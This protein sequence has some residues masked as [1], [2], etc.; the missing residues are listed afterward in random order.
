QDDLGEQDHQDQRNDEHADKWP[1]LADDG[2]E[3]DA[4]DAIDHEQHHAVGRRDQA[5]HAI[6]HRD[7]AEIDQVDPQGPAARDEQR[8]H[9]QDDRRGV[10]Q[11]AQ[12]QQDEIDDDEEGERVEVEAFEV[13]GHVGGDVL[14]RHDVVE[15]QRATDDDADRGGLTGARGQHVIEATP[16]QSAIDRPRQQKGI[17]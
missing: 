7:N 10:E 13:G 16:A 8:Q 3:R 14:G 17:A 9:H 5:N 6:H 2:A 12:K 15:N 11:A 4:G 1:N